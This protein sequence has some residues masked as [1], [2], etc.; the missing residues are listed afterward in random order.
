MVRTE[1]MHKWWVVRLSRQRNNI[2]DTVTVKFNFQN[3]NFAEPFNEKRIDIGD[4]SGT[5]KSLLQ[6]YCPDFIA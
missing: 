3:S 1:Q 2:N 6:L 4:I 5:E